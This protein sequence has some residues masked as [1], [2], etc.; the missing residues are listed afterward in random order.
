MYMPV[1]RVKLLISTDETNGIFPGAIV[2]N[3]KLSSQEGVG[4]RENNP[5]LLLRNQKESSHFSVVMTLPFSRQHIY[6]RDCP[7]FFTRAPRV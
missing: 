4:I 6:D 2:A 3:A 5:A 7:S 1:G